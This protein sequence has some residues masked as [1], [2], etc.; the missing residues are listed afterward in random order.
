MVSDSSRKLSHSLSCW[1]HANL[2]LIKQ[3]KWRRPQSIH[4]HR[5]R[6]APSLCPDCW[7]TEK[8]WFCLFLKSYL[9]VPCKQIKW[10][11]FLWLWDIKILTQVW[12][13]ACIAYF[14]WIKYYSIH[15]YSILFCLY[16]F[17][18]WSFMLASKYL[19]LSPTHM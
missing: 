1:L 19:Y 12:R 13:N 16:S 10:Q 15:L 7:G 9:I 4:S 14:S 18:T 3:Q 6:C 17:V 5:H 8:K 11:N 2:L